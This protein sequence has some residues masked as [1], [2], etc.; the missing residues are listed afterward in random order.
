METNNMRKNGRYSCT[1]Y[2]QTCFTSYQIYY[3]LFCIMTF[4]YKTQWSCRWPVTRF[5]DERKCALMP[6]NQACGIKRWSP[7]A[8]IEERVCNTTRLLAD[9]NNMAH[10]ERRDETTCHGAGKDVWWKNNIIRNRPSNE[11]WRGKTT[12]RGYVNQT[13][14]TI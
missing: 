11:Q 13:N 8:V 14:K 5:G 10:N 3:Y 7:V 1:S 2:W 6:K 9:M 12:K 4:V